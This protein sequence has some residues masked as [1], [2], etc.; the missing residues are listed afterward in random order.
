MTLSSGIVRT[1]K[2]CADDGKIY[3]PIIGAEEFCVNCKHYKRA[4]Y[5]HCGITECFIPWPDCAV[6]A[7]YE[8]EEER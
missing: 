5:G 4:P 3:W 6:C 1:H 8:K 7:K 2:D